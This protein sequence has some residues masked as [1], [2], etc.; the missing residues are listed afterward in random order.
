M[1]IWHECNVC[2]SINHFRIEEIEK[3]EKL[4]GFSRD[5]KIN[6]CLLKLNKKFEHF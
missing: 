6:G 2:C 3:Y 4:K 5:G 1:I